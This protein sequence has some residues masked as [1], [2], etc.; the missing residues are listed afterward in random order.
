[1]WS[2]LTL[3]L[4]WVF[5]G[6]RMTLHGTVWSSR[7]VSICAVFVQLSFLCLGDSL[8]SVQT[9]NTSKE[10]ASGFV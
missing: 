2:D 8:H 7:C 4:T 1:M 3:F 5:S 9:R 10:D 6:G